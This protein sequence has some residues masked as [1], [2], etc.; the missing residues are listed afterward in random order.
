MAG[1]VLASGELVGLAQADAPPGHAGREMMDLVPAWPLGRSM[2]D[3]ETTG[4][5]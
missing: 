4:C 2:D 3:E 1:H 5:P